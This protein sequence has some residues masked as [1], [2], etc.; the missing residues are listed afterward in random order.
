[1]RAACGFWVGL[2]DID[3]AGKRVGA[4][5]AIEHANQLTARILDRLQGTPDYVTIVRFGVSGHVKS[6]TPAWLSDAYN[7]PVCRTRDA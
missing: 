3:R 5:T 4:T 1:M 6:Q 2:A 7:R